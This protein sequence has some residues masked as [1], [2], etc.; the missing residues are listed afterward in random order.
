MFKDNGLIVSGGSALLLFTFFFYFTRRHIFSPVQFR[1]T[2]NI[3]A[4][5]GY[6]HADLY[7]IADSFFHYGK[8]SDLSGARLSFT[9]NL[10]D[11]IIDGKNLVNNQ[12]NDSNEIKKK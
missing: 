6:D 9:L 3:Q 11:L 2:L 8:D 7:K 5:L 12:D 4:I 1:L 10:K